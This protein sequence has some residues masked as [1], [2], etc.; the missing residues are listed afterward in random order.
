VIERPR[1][2]ADAR[3]EKVADSVPRRRPRVWGWW[4]RAGPAGQR[5]CLVDLA[6]TRHSQVRESGASGCRT[7]GAARPHPEPRQHSVSQVQCEDEVV[8][9]ARPCQHGA[10]GGLLLGGHPIEAV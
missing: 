7:R 10:Y 1:N 2:H 6:Q 3:A 5:G 4:L 9:K 8:H